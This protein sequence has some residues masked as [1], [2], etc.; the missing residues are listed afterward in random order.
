MMTHIILWW[1]IFFIIW[2]VISKVTY[3]TTTLQNFSLKWSNTF[4]NV[5]I[6]LKFVELTHMMMT[7]FSWYIMWTQRSSKV[8]KGHFLFKNVTIYSI[9]STFIYVRIFMKFFE[10]TPIMMKHFFHN[11]ICD[12]RGHRRS[13]KVMK[14]VNIYNTASTFC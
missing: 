3:I 9:S 1:S 13:Q 4:I 10:H 5:W 12:L 6:F 8:T 11:M 2:H 14:K 7:L